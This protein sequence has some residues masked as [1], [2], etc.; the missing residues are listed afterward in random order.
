MNRQEFKDQ[1]AEIFFI[2]PSYVVD[3]AEIA[4][5]GWDSLALLSVIGIA[6]E[7]FG[8]E[9]TDTQLEACVTVHDLLA[10]FDGYWQESHND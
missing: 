2:D 5:L 9:I 3:E 8:L 10:T 4:N 6:E 1:L 7:E